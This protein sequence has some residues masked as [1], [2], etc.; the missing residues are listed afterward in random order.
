MKLTKGYEDSREKGHMKF[1]GLAD[2]NNIE[3]RSLLASQAI[4]LTFE[5]SDEFQQRSQCFGI[6]VNYSWCEGSFGELEK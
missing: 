2:T 6:E 5:F 1:M 3:A 4:L